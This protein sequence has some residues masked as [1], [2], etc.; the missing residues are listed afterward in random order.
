VRFELSPRRGE[1][2]IA[3]AYGVA[4]GGRRREAWLSVED[5]E[6]AEYWVLMS[7]GV[8]VRIRSMQFVFGGREANVLG[9]QLST[10][11]AGSEMPAMR[12]ER[13]RLRAR[14]ELDSEVALV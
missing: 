9:R 4:K 10:L 13:E 11:S 7:F 5:V 1:T 2:V 14:R 6:L 8:V 12:A 3:K